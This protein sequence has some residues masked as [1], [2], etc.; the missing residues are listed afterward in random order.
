[1][2]TFVRSYKSLS[3]SDTAFNPDFLLFTALPALGGAQGMGLGT[4]CLALVIS[5]LQVSDIL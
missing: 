3:Q 2:F 4:I 1:M 5:H